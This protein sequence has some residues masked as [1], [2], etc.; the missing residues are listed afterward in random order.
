MASGVQR[1]C[2]GAYALCRRSGLMSSRLGQS[3]FVPAYF[4]YKRRWEAPW[5]GLVAQLA[6]PGSLAV[7]AGAN[8]GFFAREL[9]SAVGPSGRV[10]AFEPDA[11]NCAVLQDVL[12]RGGHANASVVMAALGEKD[13]TVQLH[14]NADHP[15]DHRV[16]A[17][18]GHEAGP[19]VPLRSLD[20]VLAQEGGGR[21]LSVVKIDVQ[22]A[23]LRV[24]RGMRQTLLRHPRARLLLEFDPA[25]LAESGASAE[26][27]ADFLRGLGFLAYRLGP[28]P[29]A[30][31]L[32]WD[33][34]P[35]CARQAG[36]IDLLLTRQPWSSK[37]AAKSTNTGMT[38]MRKRTT[39]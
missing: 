1:L 34:A 2:L 19:R 28:G 24:L 3:L 5:I 23:E 20:Q 15:A 13:G 35:V 10:L 36:S 29:A 31:P 33:S 14:L 8:I 6:E 16:Y 39:A 38:G 26:E 18:A 9:A 27:L 22:G 17:A 11:A 37:A 32:S 12:R 30:E 25:M 21:P 4:F 7:D